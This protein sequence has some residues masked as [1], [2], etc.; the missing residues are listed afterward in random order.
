MILREVGVSAM[1]TIS[2]KSLMEKIQK[3]ERLLMNTSLFNDVRININSWSDTSNKVSLLA[4][5]KEA[6]FIYPIPIF[7]LADRNFNVWWVE[8]KRTI[9]RINFG[10]RLYHLNTTGNRDQIKL[11]TQFGYTPKYEV[12]YQFPYINKASTLGLYTNLLYSSNK[13][14]GYETSQNKLQFQ[15]NNNEVVYRQFRSTIGLKYR[16]DIHFEHAIYAKYHYQWVSPFVVDSLSRN[17]FSSNNQKQQ[18]IGLQ[19]VFIYDTRDIKPYPIKGLYT[20]LSLEGEGLG[21]FNDHK[22]IFLT[23]DFNAFFPINNF[24]SSNLHLKARASLLSHQ[25]GYRSQR[26]LGYKEDY[27]RGYEYYVIDGEHFLLGKVKFKFEVFRKKY[28]LGQVMPIRQFQKLPLK[29]FVALNGD[30]GYVRGDGFGHQNTFVN[31]PLWG[32][33]IGLDFVIYFDKIIQ[34][35][36]SFNHIGENG[37]F[38]HYK[39]AF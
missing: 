25:T 36:Y 21:I 12:Q 23:G 6:F 14:I 30:W 7:E 8:K 39:F 22:A 28:E 5:V 19:Y 24:I 10:L 2:I 4:H 1:D 27:L 17:Y 26:A 29:I 34:L 32:G 18:F 35:E 13:E 11:V 16:K 15:R 3:G 20:L 37:L 9:N 31:R 33:G 38:L